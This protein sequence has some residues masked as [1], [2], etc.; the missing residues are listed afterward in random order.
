MTEDLFLEVLPV[1]FLI[2]FTILF[3]EVLHIIIVVA[4]LL[5]QACTQKYL[6]PINFYKRINIISVVF[7]F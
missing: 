6:Y 3:Y 7:L 5:V 4:I 1:L 2:I